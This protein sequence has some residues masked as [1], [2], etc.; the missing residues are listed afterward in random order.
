M[1]LIRSKIHEVGRKISCKTVKIS[2]LVTIP[3]CFQGNN[4]ISENLTEIHK[5]TCLQYSRFSKKFY[6][7]CHRNQRE[8]NATTD[9]TIM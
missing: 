1:T 4:G 5:Y 8:K 7:V 2:K 6:E 9:L 3:F